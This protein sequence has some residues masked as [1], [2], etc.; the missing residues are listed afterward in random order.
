MLMIFLNKG[1]IQIDI[2]L[3]K[4]KLIHS[5]EAFFQFIE[6]SHKSIHE[7]R[8][9]EYLTMYLAIYFTK[10]KQV[11]RYCHSKCLWNQ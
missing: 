7:L 1:K 11:Y 6:F 4:K 3:I 2:I 5:S 9:P 10:C 8:N